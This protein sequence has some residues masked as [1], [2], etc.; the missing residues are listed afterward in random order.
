MIH[1][2]KIY[3]VT[4]CY[5]D[6]NK[7]YI[8]K[9]KNSRKSN[10]K[11]K[12]GDQIT[13]DYIDEISSPNVKDWVLLETYWIHQFRQW[14]FEV[15][16]K[17]EG[18]GGPITQSFETKEKIR[19]AQTGN[20]YSLGK[21][22]TEEHKL[23]MSLSKIG[24]PKPEGFGE[25]ISKIKLTQNIKFSEE[26]KQKISESKKGNKYNLGKIKSEETKQKISKSMIGKNK[27]NK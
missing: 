16:N 5:N 24:K 20:K 4:N 23:N 25:K 9:T 13:Y 18:G 6:P 27:K 26:H 22:W 2:A 11:R 3:L 15:L 19:N 10:H 12:F 7:V 14:G 21:K 17:N 1:I 8:G